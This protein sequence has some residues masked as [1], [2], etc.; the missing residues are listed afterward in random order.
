MPLGRLGRG[1]AGAARF[2]LPH[3][4]TRKR[5]NRSRVEPFGLRSRRDTDMSRR[6][7]IPGPLRDLVPADAHAAL[8]AAGVPVVACRTD[9]DRPRPGRRAMS[10]SGLE[11]ASLLILR[12]ARDPGPDR[13][14]NSRTRRIW[15]GRVT[16]W[17]TRPGR[18]GPLEARG[19]S[20]PGGRSAP[21]VRAN[22]GDPRRDRARRGEPVDL[23]A[24]HRRTCG[25]H[26]RRT[27]TSTSP[28]RR[29]RSWAIR[30]AGSRIATTPP[31]PRWPSGRS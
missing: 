17:R 22:M 11:S 2:R 26:A 14:A 6:P 19:P 7:P 23:R 30:S 15:P 5:G 20:G 25:R 1:N 29:S 27:M 12:A 3:G 18:V 24:G 8:R 21:R 31:A 9:E 4:G 13:V 28:S 16:R 10:R